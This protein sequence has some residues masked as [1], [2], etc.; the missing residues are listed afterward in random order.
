MLKYLA[1]K[2]TNE[3]AGGRLNWSHI[4]NPLIF[5]CSLLVVV[6]TQMFTIPGRANILDAETFFLIPCV[7]FAAANNQRFSDFYLGF[8]KN[9]CYQPSKALI[10]L[11]QQ[12]LYWLLS[13]IVISFAGIIIDE[14]V[15]PVRLELYVAKTF[16]MFPLVLSFALVWTL[17][18]IDNTVALVEVVGDIMIPSY[19]AYPMD[20]VWQATG[21]LLPSEWLYKAIIALNLTSMDEQALWSYRAISDPLGVNWTIQ[22]YGVGSWYN[23]IGS[24]QLGIILTTCE[25]LTAIA[26]F[27]FW[28]IEFYL[29]FRKPRVE[30]K[31]VAATHE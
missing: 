29:Q 19:P 14:V 4:F 23:T 5:I 25:V 20:N 12:A 16:V 7:K 6:N 15:R 28:I 18:A 8:E 27:S 24:A 2:H 3:K 11:Y 30:Q 22:A 13:A 10:I 17:A 1:A 26:A 21:N 31:E 9:G